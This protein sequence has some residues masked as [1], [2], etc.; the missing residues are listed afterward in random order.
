MKLSFIGIACILCFQLLGCATPV[1]KETK[2]TTLSK[3]TTL[4][5]PMSIALYTGEKKPN[6]PYV[7]I[8]KKTI[9]KFNQVGI[10]RQE[11]NI[12]DVMRHTAANIGGD[13]VID[14]SN[15]ANSVTG[16]IIAFKVS[17]NEAAE[18]A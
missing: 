18:R 10:K 2:P 16:T 11:A 13:A 1:N 6:K 9:S 12:R 14:I 15:D 17:E 4:K 5:N 3:K 8:A 7:I